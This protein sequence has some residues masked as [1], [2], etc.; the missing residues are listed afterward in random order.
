MLIIRQSLANPDQACT[1]IAGQVERWQPGRLAP[2][3]HLRHQV[4]YATRGVVH[5][6]TPAGQWI[7]PPSRAIWIGGGIPHGL[8]VKRPA[9]TRVLYIDPDAYDIPGGSAC[10]V[11]DV[12]PLVR[13][14]I[15]ACAEFPADYTADSPQGR[16]AHVLIDQLQAL[17]Q[18]PADIP[19]PTDPRALRIVAIL[20]H[21]PANR[22]PLAS[23]CRHAGA[24]ARTL[25]RL[26][27]LETR[28]SFGAWRYRLRLLTAMEQ[29]AYGASVTQ[30]ALEVGYESASSFIAAFRSMFGKTPAKYF[31]HD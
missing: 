9:E 27:S 15:L 29:L 13:E 30:A 22:E 14:L 20:Q 11:L 12:P 8:E 18:A 3:R 16:M 17:E 10:R 26:F 6:A 1:P 28:M 5:V 21:D 31:G 23:L 19:M 7:L 25:E 24:S 4:I 2:H